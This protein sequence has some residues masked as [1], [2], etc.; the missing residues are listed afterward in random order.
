MTATR[1]LPA[2]LRS[3]IR[4][5]GPLTV[6]AFMD[7]AL[8]HPTHGY[9]ARV[10]RRS[11]RSGDFFTSVDLGP[12]FGQ[13]LATQ[14]AEMGGHVATGDGPF[15]LIDA[16]ASD[17]RLARS[18]LDGLAV[19]SPALSARTHAV[20][21]E[22][23]ADARA[24][25]RETLGPWQAHTESRATLP[26][27]FSGVLVA[28]ELLDAM[29]VHQVVMRAGG[30]REVFVGLD[31]DRFITVESTPSSDAVA[32]YLAKAGV[33]LPLGARA[34]ISPEAVAW[35]RHAAT[36]LQQ[37]FLILVDYGQRAPNLFGPQRPT[38]TLTAYRRHRQTSAGSGAWLSD[39]GEQDLTAHVDFTSVA[40]AA[41]AAGCSVLGLL[42]QTYFLMA[43]GASR[44]GQFD[45]ATRRAF[46][47]LVLPG[48]LGS[49]M[50][51]LVLAKGVGTP[52]LTGLGAATRLT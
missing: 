25:H 43:L 2:L 51:V 15:T 33:T 28:N 16:G 10:P 22:Q 32:S 38:G 46:Q 19:E 4:E 40:A 39:P 30:L 1:V 18:M 12:L 35:V 50:K 49:T 23:S 52:A 17:G 9:Y 37:G 6:A 3:H 34:D 31:D 26:E 21:I 44:L 36:S 5:R 42:D 47:S 24:R 29:P 7:L 14:I 20:L 41:E 48:G 13:L 45:Q 8:Y 11:G 27:H